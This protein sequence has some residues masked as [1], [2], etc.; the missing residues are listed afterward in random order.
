[1][2]LE[3]FR[4][5]WAT[6][7]ANT[8]EK[9]FL[10][11]VSGGI[12]SMALASLMY[13]SSIKFAVAHCNFGLRGMESDLD[14]EL[15]AEWCRVHRVEFHQRK[16]D[17]KNEMAIRKKGLQE[18][19]RDL[20]Y[21]WF[22]TLC[23][24]H[25]YERIVTAHHADDNVETLIIKVFRGTGLSGLHGILPDNDGV[26]RPLLFTTRADVERY[27]RAQNVPYREDVSNAS[28]VYLRNS[29]RHKIIPVVKE[30][31]PN[32]VLQANSSIYRFTEA[33]Y[34]YQK[35]LDAEKRKHMEKRGNDY[36]IPVRKLE[37]HP[38]INTLLYELL[39]PFGYGQDQLPHVL[40]LLKAESGHYVASSTHR[41]IRNREFLVVTSLPTEAA[42]LVLVEQIPEK[43]RLSTC[44]I[45]FSEHKDKSII[46]T[47]RSV[48]CVDRKMVEFPLVIRRLKAGD[49]FY[50]FGM[51][52]KK[53]KISR[54]L[55]DQ[56]VA[57]HEKEN[58]WVVESAKR[59]IWVVGMRMDERFRI[60]DHSE[61]MMMIK[62]SEP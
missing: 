49:Y 16:F 3:E 38:V 53:K 6:L 2:L 29:V 9:T 62:V 28:D 30:V 34:F 25:K 60:T 37:T 51:K 41:V 59:I 56:K 21:E 4:K 55:I 22:R 39:R 27:V 61:K 52:M 32:A 10:L 5:N 36:Y 44:T 54:Y 47:D 17:T 19:A 26:L 23:A 14:E 24:S 7:A 1:M 50:P 35:A 33:E 48:A 46:P 43:V 45:S 8:H 20:R 31:F 42:D 11:A 57:L 15:V 58:I 18:T 40:N 12:D 13:R